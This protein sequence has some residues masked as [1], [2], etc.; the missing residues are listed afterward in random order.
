[1]FDFP[2]LSIL[3]GIYGRREP[4]V[5]RPEDPRY[6]VV[7]SGEV[8]F[9]FKLQQSYRSWLGLHW[10]TIKTSDYISVLKEYAAE[11]AKLPIYLDRYGK[12]L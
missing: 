2:S 5:R 10:R 12:E 4:S 7:E 8:W 11:H 1:M 9:R 3:S 6:R